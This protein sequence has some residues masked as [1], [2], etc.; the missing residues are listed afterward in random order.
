MRAREPHRVTLNPA[1]LTPHRVINAK[2]RIDIIER[3]RFRRSLIRSVLPFKC[4]R[5]GR[6]GRHGG[7]K[8]DYEHE[9]DYEHADEHEHEP[10]DAVPI[11][12]G[13]VYPE[14]WRG[15]QGTPAMSRAAGRRRV[16]AQDDNK[17]T[18]DGHG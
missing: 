4:F 18:T 12:S 1:C 7:G 14:P 16:D 5:K 10:F 11:S 3:R 8:H 9:N 6:G 15:A 2:L 17:E 13:R